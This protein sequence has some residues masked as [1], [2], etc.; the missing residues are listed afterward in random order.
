MKREEMSQEVQ[1]PEETQVTQEIC[2]TLPTPDQE[3]TRVTRA[4]LINN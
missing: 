4:I 2:Q 1:E 3:M